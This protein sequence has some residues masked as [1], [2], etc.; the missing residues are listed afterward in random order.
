[1]ALFTTQPSFAT[2]KLDGF[3][4]VKSILQPDGKVL[5]AG[6][7]PLGAIVARFDSNGQLDLS[8]GNNGNG[9]VKIANSSATSFLRS[10]ALNP[11]G[12]ITA[13]TGTSYVELSANGIVTNEYLV[14]FKSL[15]LSNGDWYSSFTSR[16]NDGVVRDVVVR[17][18]KTGVTSSEQ[19]RSFGDN[20]FVALK[21]SDPASH[22]GSLVLTKDGKLIVPAISST[23]GKITSYFEV[24]ADGKVATEHA[25]QD[26][27]SSSGSA[28]SL[29]PE[30]A[31]PT[32]NFFRQA[33]GKVVTFS[34]LGDGTYSLT[35][36][37]ADGSTDLGFGKAGSATGLGV[38]QSIAQQPDGK[39]VLNLQSASVVVQEGLTLARYTVN[40]ELD[41]TFYGGTVEADPTSGKDY[42]YGVTVQADGKIVVAGSSGVNILV[43]RYLPDGRLDPSF[44]E[45]G[46]VT[47]G[48]GQSGGGFG[49]SSRVVSVNV[50]AD[51]KIIVFGSE[52]MFSQK[53]M[54]LR[55]N[56]DGS[57][58]ASYGQPFYNM[59]GTSG[60]DTFELFSLKNNFI[61]GLGG[62][63]TLVLRSETKDWSIVKQ[64]T[65]WL[66]SNKLNP[67]Y[68]ATLENVE[69][70]NFMFGTAGRA[71]T[72][73]LQ[74]SSTGTQ[75]GALTKIKV[76]PEDATLTGTT[77]TDV[78]VYAGN[79]AG[80]T[81]Q[82]KS[83]TVTVSSL[84]TGNQTL[85]N[86]ERLQFNDDVVAFDIDGTAGK[87]YRL[88][89]AA[90]DRAPD[91]AGLGWQ[92][93]AI[94]K[95]LGMLQVA[96]NF[97]ESA[98]FKMR[99]GENLSNAGLVNQLYQNVLH[100]APDAAGFQV[101][102][103]ALDTGMVSRAQ[104]L[105]NFSESAEN[106][107]NVIG[108]IKNGIEFTYFA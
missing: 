12:S 37:N 49:I 26:F 31:L 10:I 22:P 59:V 104:L 102:L 29:F 39:L 28:L 38:V 58:D 1:M 17:Y 60:D 53:P 18:I 44:G 34:S 98:E 106:Q 42:L 101:Q 93:S 84:T 95:G 25:P 77:G 61:D 14:G 78:A 19:D 91:E 90:F 69:R 47:G 21:A 81:I 68:S 79:R 40:G 82:N 20:G 4:P 87:A 32:A 75:V 15:T 62:T 76:S 7:S 99:Y 89:Q 41:K 100:R 88:Y 96:Q 64:G 63:D 50:Q 105:L 35:R 72:V 56:A 86:V 65:G 94:D 36:Y 67:E 107:V 51:G 45:G 55:L 52:G 5:I 57:A 23:T 97:M 11:N 13:S 71:E 70:I 80:F 74:S 48:F 92:I 103:N 33:D 83:G 2:F 85:T 66:L 16:Q 108:V 46:I 6:S 30:I 9:V 3:V 73:T 43:M 54:V 8:F 27:S 24:S